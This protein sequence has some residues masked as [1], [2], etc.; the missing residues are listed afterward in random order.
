VTTTVVLWTLNIITAG[1]QA[2][3]LIDRLG[4]VTLNGVVITAGEMLAK[5]AEVTLRISGREL[6]S[7]AVD[8]TFVFSSVERKDLADAEITARWKDDKGQFLQVALKLGGPLETVRLKLPAGASA[9]K[10]S[11]F[12][13]SGH[14]V[15]L[16]VNGQL[17]PKW[18]G[19]Q[20]S[21]VFVAGTPA[22]T[23]LKRWVNEYAVAPGDTWFEGEF[24]T[25]TDG[26]DARPLASKDVPPGIRR[27]F[28]GSLIPDRLEDGLGAHFD[29]S[30]DAAHRLEEFKPWLF[31]NVFGTAA[32]RLVGAEAF[33]LFSEGPTRRFLNELSEA[34]VPSDF[35]LLA[36]YYDEC[37]SGY[38]FTLLPRVVEVRSL[39]IEALQDLTFGDFSI[40]SSDAHFRTT[41]SV[42]AEFI[43][44]APEKVR[45]FNRGLKRG[46]TLVVPLEITFRIPENWGDFRNGEPSEASASIGE[47]GLQGLMGFGAPGRLPDR[48]EESYTFGPASVIEAVTANGLSEPIRQFDPSRMFISSGYEGGSCPIISSRFSSAAPWHREGHLLYG[49][50]D[51]SRERWDELTIRSFD[52]HLLIEE[53]DP[54][55]S[56]IDA[57]EVR[58]EFPDGTFQLI[59]PKLEELL[60][61][62]QNYLRLRQGQ[63]VILQFPE[64]DLKRPAK[65]IV[66]RTKGFY[67]P[68]S[69]VG[70]TRVRLPAV[71]N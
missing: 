3:A 11:Y 65:R 41:P 66:V 18:L 29:E 49:I 54:E 48:L 37:G 67:Q 62:D 63:K 61:D 60:R 56:Y 71:P 20:D 36:G 27:V 25:A 22:V 30:I 59:R 23:L 16:L 15:D 43:R 7:V 70:Q 12:I 10:V 31:A 33:P 13:A 57:L 21:R 44:Q 58:R 26:A 19:E 69:S 53:H 38:E 4:R 55:W 8:G 42:Q 34:N 1:W 14:A 64:H 5:N 52:G 51:R 45:L 17:P 50:N 28:L 40:R 68:F 9:F 2:S 24:M 6:V 39:L 35:A 32:I 46:E 47:I